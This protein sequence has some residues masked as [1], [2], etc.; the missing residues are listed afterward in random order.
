[1]IDN[2]IIERVRNVDVIAFLERHQGF[3]FAHRG[4][5]YR[6]EQHKSLAVKN[7]RL[8]WYWHS[9]SIGGHGVLDYL[10][11]AEN[12]PFRDAVEAVLGTA[13][14]SPP[15]ARVKLTRSAEPPKTLI[16]PE[17]AGIPLRLYDYLCKRR[18]IDG[19]IVST[20]LNRDK[21]YEDRRGNVVFVGYDEYLKPRFASVRGTHGDFRGDCAGSDKRYGFSISGFSERLYVFESPI[22]S[23]SH[24]T[25]AKMEYGDMAVWEHDSRLSLAGATDTAMPFFLNQHTAVKEI[26]FCLDN[27]QAGREASYALAQKYADKRYSVMIDP[28]VKKDYNEDLHTFTELINEAKRRTKSTRRDVDI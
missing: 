7:D 1:M 20:L 5:A 13:T 18:G 23:M 25:L 15:Q 6:C 27:D 22:D 11:K 3:T 17:K 19:E 8:S 12:M 14:P 28:P 9:K 26:V 21:L 24:A 2:M 16:L 10:V 4:G